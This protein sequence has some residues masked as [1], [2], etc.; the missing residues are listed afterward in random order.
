MPIFG[1]PA[2]GGTPSAH[3]TQSIREAVE[4]LLLCGDPAGG[5]IPAKQKFCIPCVL[6]VSVVKIFLKNQ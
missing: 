6:C 4:L 2:F 3:E 1:N 5:R